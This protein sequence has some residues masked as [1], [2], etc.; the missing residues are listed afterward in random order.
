MRG[1]RS[2]ASANGSR[3]GETSCSKR[4]ESPY[5]LNPVDEAPS[6]GT[7]DVAQYGL[8]AIQNLALI[9]DRLPR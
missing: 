4:I 9:G 7:N 5:V 3:T 6:V 8:A 1:K 2:R